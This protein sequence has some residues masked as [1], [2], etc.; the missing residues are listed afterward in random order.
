MLSVMSL[1]ALRPKETPSRARASQHANGVTTK[2]R[3]MN[4]DAEENEYRVETP[5]DIELQRGKSRS[6]RRNADG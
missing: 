4:G 5:T 1:L 3:K 6:R 2:Q